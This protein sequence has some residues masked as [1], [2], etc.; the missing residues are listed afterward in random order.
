MTA[1]FDKHYDHN[2]GVCRVTRFIRA[3]VVFQTKV[4]IDQSYPDQSYAKLERWDGSKWHVTVCRDGP[5]FQKP[6]KTRT[7]FS[8]TTP[9]EASVL[10]DRLTD[11]LTS[12]AEIF[13]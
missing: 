3:R 13:V 11:E 7:G 9:Q 8:F 12:E 5:E 10:R 2:Q 4:W 1:Y 6:D